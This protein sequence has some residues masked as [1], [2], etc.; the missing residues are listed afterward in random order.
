ME[1]MIHLRLISAS[2]NFKE[3]F[4]PQSQRVIII[5]S[6][7]E[8][9]EIFFYTSRKCSYFNVYSFVS[10]ANRKLKFEEFV[11][12]MEALIIDEN[13]NEEPSLD[14]IR[15]FDPEELGFVSSEDLKIA[16]KSMPGSAYMS[17]FE[18]RDILQK[19]DPDKDGKID[20]QG[21]YLKGYS[22]LLN[23][24]WWKNFRWGGELKFYSRMNFCV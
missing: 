1:K 15:V 13:E 16:L 4:H 18:L 21:N 14:S 6:R 5:R 3:D 8:V 7:N 24:F 11:R 2:E 23:I 10:L 9:N 19:A 17:D 22:Y 20:I 12:L